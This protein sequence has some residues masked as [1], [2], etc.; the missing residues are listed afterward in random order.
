MSDARSDVAS[1]PS[2]TAGML[3]S[4]VLSVV[5]GLVPA[6]VPGGAAAIVEACE[7]ESEDVDTY[8]DDCSPSL[9]TLLDGCP[10]DGNRVL[11]TTVVDEMVGDIGFLLPKRHRHCCATGEIAI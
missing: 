6:L 8:R 11:A 5:T 9:S 10:F 7:V 2:V 3:S 4:S 1:D